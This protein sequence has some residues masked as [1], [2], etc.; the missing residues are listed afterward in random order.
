MAYTSYSPND[1]RFGF[2]T[3]GS[4][5]CAYENQRLIILWFVGGL[6]F[7]AIAFV[8]ILFAV[9][10][11]VMNPE[12][13]DFDASK[14]TIDRMDIWGF[15]VAIYGS[16]LTA[17]TAII[18]IEVLGL[19]AFC[20][21]LGL[22]RTGQKY[23]FIA[24]ENYFEI[25]PPKEELPHIIV[26]Y[27]DVIMI[28]G[29]ERKFIFAEHGLDVTIKMKKFSYFFRYI[30]TPDSRLNGLSNTPFNIIME[31]AELIRKPDVRI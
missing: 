17:L 14:T 28:F 12:M 21:T 27:N 22:L 23:G 31:R 15:D 8:V 11:L 3:Q 26:N 2:K 18:C 30:H 5:R 4:F 20:I 16:Y 25:I 10:E 24:N 6:I 9:R 7:F 19:M 1:E 29:E 13:P